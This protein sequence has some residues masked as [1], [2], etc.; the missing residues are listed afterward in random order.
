MTRC[1]NCDEQLDFWAVYRSFL[2]GYDPISCPNC[3]V[4]YVHRTSN[5]LLAAGSIL[6]LLLLLFLLGRSVAAGVPIL[7][8]LLAFLLAS[9]LVSLALV[10]L[11]RFDRREI[12][13]SKP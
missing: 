10:P 3:G 13:E 12:S 4:E 1:Q 9:F 7:W 8:Q 6:V 5:R 2:T 11:L